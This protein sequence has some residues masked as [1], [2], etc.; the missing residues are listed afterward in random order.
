MSRRSP[1]I[2]LAV[3][4]LP[5]L[6]VSID[7]TVLGT[8]LPALAEDLR[9]GAAAQLWIVDAYSFVLAG[10]L[11][12][13]GTLGDRIGRRRLLLWGS[14][15]FGVAS[16]LA[17][18]APSAGTLVAARALLGIGG[19]TLLPSTF[20]LI[21]TVFPE[22]RRRATAVAVWSAAFAG[23]AAAGPVVA[24]VLL[25]HFWWGAVFLVNVPVIALLLAVGPVAVPESRDPHPGPFDLPSAALSLVAMLP[26][27][28]ALKTLAT[29]GATG[30]AGLAAALGVVAGAVFVRRQRRLAHPL[31]DLDLF[32]RRAF[33]V[34][35]T[36]NLLGVFALVGLLLLLP[37]YLQ[38]VLGMG[39]L[40]AALW[41]LPGSVAGVAG[42]LG[43]ARLGRHLGA[44]ALVGLGF[45][46]AA[47]GLLVVALVGGLA[48]VVAGFVLLGGGVALAEALTNDLILAAAPADRAGAAS[49]ISETGYE[50]GGALGTAVLGSIAA[51]VFTGRTGQETLGGAVAHAAGMPAEAGAT[52]LADAGEAFVLGLQGAAVVGTVVL[53]LTAVGAWRLLRRDTATADREPAA[54]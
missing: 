46:T 52:L 44:P 54:V 30:G 39:P 45:A 35:V 12:T 9:P 22:P 7:M 51:A 32:A 13:M 31:L 20:S 24:G 15:A 34:S 42:A 26:L 49:A 38:L 28:Y 3:L 37:Q 40:T 43:G 6:L 25:E 16:V 8:A 23:G 41:M 10:L 2:A 48:G 47:A 14:A 21:K 17:A 4:V 50:L 11:V 36:A 5:V 53:A 19:A 33:S 27:V 29:E 1:W 18:V